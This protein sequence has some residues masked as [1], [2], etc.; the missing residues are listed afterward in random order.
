LAL[1][2]RNVVSLTASLVEMLPS[3]TYVKMDTFWIQSIKTLAQRVTQ[4][5]KHVLARQ[6]AMPTPHRPAVATLDTI[7]QL[8][9]LARV[10]P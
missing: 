7:E 1:H 5:V 6:H 4:I 2:V 8:W 10:V 3:A 9:E